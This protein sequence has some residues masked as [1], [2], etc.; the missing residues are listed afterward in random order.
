M[1]RRLLSLIVVLCA[2]SFVL[3]DE[4]PQRPPQLYRASVKPH[5]LTD[6]PCFWYRNDLPH[7]GRE[8]VFVDASRATRQPALDHQRLADIFTQELGQ[9]VSATHLPI[10]ALEYDDHDSMQLHGAKGVWRLKLSDYTLSRIEEQSDQT[11]SLPFDRKV[12]PS[13]STGP[14][15]EIRFENR[16]SHPVE[17]LW[18]DPSGQQHSY[19]ILTPGDTH[20][21]HTY[22]GHVW[23]IKS[24]ERD[25]I[26]VFEARRE[27]SLAIIDTREP[28]RV[29]PR[30]ERR[31]RRGSDHDARSPD[32]QWRAFARDNNLWLRKLDDDSEKQLTEDGSAERTWRKDVGRARGIRMRYKLPDPPASAV[33]VY[34]SGDSQYFV[35]IRT[36]TATE[37]RVHLIETAPSD[38]TQPRLHSYPYFKPGDQIPVQELGLFEAHNGRRVEIDHAQFSNP[39]AISD[40]RWSP[41]SS[42][43]TFV[44]NQRGH[45]VLRLIGVDAENGDVRTIVDEQSESFVDYAGKNFAHHVDDTNELIWMSERDGWNH[46]YLVDMTS[47]DVKAQITKGEWVVR[48]VQRLDEAERQIWFRAGGLYPEQDPYHVHFARVN[49]DGSGLCV[50]TEGDGTHEIEFSPDGDYFIDKW[51][52]VDLPPVHELRRTGDGSLVCQLEEADASEVKRRLPTRFVA[53]GRDGKTDIYG[54]VHWPLGFDSTRIYPIIEN[55]YAGPHSAH[56]P[57][58]FRTR[59]GHQQQIADRGFVVV[60]ID[61][62][63]TSQRSKAFHDVCWKNLGDAGLPDRVLWIK[64]L[65][66]KHQGLDAT[67]VGIYGGSAGGQNA[68]SALLNHGDFYD[69][70]VADCGCHDNRMDKIWWNELWMG[71]PVGPHYDEQ[72]NVTNAHRLQGKLLLIVGE[73]DRNVDPASTMQVVSALVKADKDFDLLVVPGAGH[74]SAESPYGKRRRAD[75]FVKHLLDSP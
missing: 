22:T 63:G 10:D 67:R 7:G 26:A 1:H 53:K 59:Y 2:S 51:S 68:L 17:I 38:V 50:L 42:E 3:A 62:M 46:L 75:F 71:W 74:G 9:E 64:A 29:A 33:E 21:Q 47:G 27:T 12:R 70:A 16:L 32:E 34:W 65:A 14:E 44:Y 72:S 37:P 5:W 11:S 30:Q 54:I 58:S 13:R 24:D 20:T 69:A 6:R 45:Q 25:V 66:A 8:F 57:K 61:G 55:I 36:R 48:G 39:F 35:A 43:F 19:A 28:D 40:I 31:R 23:L 56:V 52:R 4:N 73:L 15:T 18:I 60:Q 49:F 41:D